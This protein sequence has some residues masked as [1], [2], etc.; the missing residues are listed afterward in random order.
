MS[1][2]SAREGQE[3]SLTEPTDRAWSGCNMSPGFIVTVT[4]NPSKVRT[5]AVSHKEKKRLQDADDGQGHGRGG[6]FR[7]VPSLE[8]LGNGAPTSHRTVLQA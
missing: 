6:L 8:D 1:R 3:Q 4:G 7:I 5:R 2:V